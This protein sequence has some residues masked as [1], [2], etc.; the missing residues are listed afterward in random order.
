MNDLNQLRQDICDIG[1]RLYDR[2]FV[3]ANDG[4][5]SVRLNENEILCT[6][7]LIS[8]GFMLPSDLCTVTVTGEHIG[9]TRK[10]S[11]EL[12]VHLEIYRHRPEVHSVLHCHPPH[13][14]AFAIT[15]EPIPAC[16]MA[17]VELF[18]GEVPT[19]PYALTGT[20]TLADSIRPFITQANIVVLANHGTVS[21]GETVEQACWWTEIL[22][23]YCR[24]LILS[25]NLGP[26]QQL[27]NE[28]VRELLEVKK[29]WGMT[30][31]RNEARFAD[32]D[33]RT[34]PLFGGE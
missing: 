30:D 5:I 29:K 24:T 26:L 12:L 1:R 33:L 8:K 19:V 20:Q 15:G 9:G 31:A 14:N 28:Q 16:V 22:D 25:R 17:E 32:T 27:S 23:A 4:N 10:P 18:L 2:G 13:V 21:C 34:R 7:T 6:P 3:A 11:S